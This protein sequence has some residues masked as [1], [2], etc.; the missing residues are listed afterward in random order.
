MEKVMCEIANWITAVATVCGSL[1]V[2]FQLKTSKD[3]AQ[4]E[5]ENSMAKEYRDLVN[6]L[7]TKALLGATLSEDEYQEAF[8]ELFHYIDLS[9]EQVF[10]RKQGR[11]GEE[12]WKSWKDGIENNLSLHAF[13]RA[14][15]Q[16]KEESDSFQELRR[17]ELSNY[18]ADPKK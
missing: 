10:L 14:W 13:K 17:L 9:N 1:F 8:D 4:Q 11:V 7:P 15:R 16:I 18:E 6:R 5:F 12:V 2:G 3:I